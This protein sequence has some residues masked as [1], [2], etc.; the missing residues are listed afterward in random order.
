MVTLDYNYF[1]FFLEGDDDERFFEEIIVPKIEDN[2][3]KIVL[4]QYAQKT[5]KSL[6][7]YIK[8]AKKMGVKFLFIK[9][10]DNYPCIT[11]L[12]NYFLLKLGPILEK[13]NILV[14]IK[15]IE[16][17][18]LAGLS[19]EKQ[20]K[21][22]ITPKYTNTNNITKEHFNRLIHEN[23]PKVQFMK[24]IIKEYNMENAKRQN[25]S[26]KYFMYKWIE[27]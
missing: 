27:N 12:K 11:A 18:Y 25:T 23:K 14:V 21:L 26:F 15:E 6:R 7:K 13:N 9:D 24:E 17:W 8:T 5:K 16:S 19:I 22:K 3:D 1:F 4:W 20:R 10:I 2:Y